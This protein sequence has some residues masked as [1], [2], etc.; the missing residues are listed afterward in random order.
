LQAAH[1]DPNILGSLK[2]PDKHENSSTAEM[3]AKC[4]LRLKRS[5]FITLRIR[6]NNEEQL[7]PRFALLAF[8]E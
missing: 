7:R 5:Y 1:S 8:E 6:S 2:Q 4:L 3:I